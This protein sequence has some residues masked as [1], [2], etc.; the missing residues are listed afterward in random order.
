MA[1]EAEEN[2]ILYEDL[3]SHCLAVTRSIFAQS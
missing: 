3:K 1:D 2:A